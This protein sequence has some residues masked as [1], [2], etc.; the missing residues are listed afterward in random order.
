[1]DDRKSD[2]FREGSTADIGAGS[3][4]YLQ[5]KEKG[6]VYVR[7]AQSGQAARTERLCRRGTHCR[8]RW[9]VAVSF[10]LSNSH[11]INLFS[12]I[13]APHC[14]HLARHF[15]NIIGDGGIGSHQAIENVVER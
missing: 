1:M 4:C 11:W 14:K 3:A 9:S 13:S 8:A 5:R 2:E 10:R 12:L 6:G 15:Q 7:N